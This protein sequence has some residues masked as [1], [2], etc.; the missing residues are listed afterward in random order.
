LSNTELISY[1]ESKH[2]LL[3]ISFLNM[4]WHQLLELVGVRY[5]LVLA[6][7]PFG[8]SYHP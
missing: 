2:L 3:Y 6:I 8:F 5:T 7:Y 1:I 4:Q